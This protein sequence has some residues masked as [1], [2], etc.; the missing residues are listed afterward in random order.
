MQPQDTNES[1]P[2]EERRLAM[3]SVDCSDFPFDEVLSLEA[4]VTNKPP[5]QVQRKRLGASSKNV[6][7]RIKPCSSVS[8]TNVN[9]NSDSPNYYTKQIDFSAIS[10]FSE[11][12]DEIINNDKSTLKFNYNIYEN[13]QN[14]SINSSLG[15]TKRKST[16]KQSRKISASPKVK[17]KP[18]KLPQKSPLTFATPQA[19]YMPETPSTTS[20]S[21]TS[22]TATPELMTSEEKPKTFFEEV[23]MLV[24]RRYNIQKLKEGKVSLNNLC[25]VI[26]SLQNRLIRLA[27]GHVVK[28]RLLTYWRKKAGCEKTLNVSDDV[29][30]SV[31]IFYL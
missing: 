8:N 21:T 25:D 11:M 6:Y 30:T 18:I 20:P 16:S 14:D 5:N 1:R 15:G 9:Q 29:I 10:H 28:E 27:E 24:G 22:L 13:P 23:E 4:T 12:F 19:I 7:K 31:L 17:P 2:D 3:E 26:D